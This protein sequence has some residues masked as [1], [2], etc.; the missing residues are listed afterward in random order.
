MAD[1][2]LSSRDVKVFP[3]AFRGKDASGAI[4]P[5]AFLT[6]EENLVNLTNKVTYL[7]KSYYYAEDGGGDSIMHIIINGYHFIVSAEKITEL[8]PNP[9]LNDNIYAS[10]FIDD[11]ATTY[12]DVDVKTLSPFGGDAGDILDREETVGSK[13]FKGLK[14]SN[15]SSSDS[16]LLFT[17]KSGSEG[18]YWSY[19]D[20][21]MVNI[22]TRQI[23]NGNDSYPITSAF[24]TDNLITHIA[25]I[26]ILYG[27]SGPIILSSHMVPGHGS[28]VL[29]DESLPF[30]NMYVSSI[31][32]SSSYYSGAYAYCDAAGYWSSSYMTQSGVDVS[33]GI[34]LSHYH[35]AGASTFRGTFWINDYD[36]NLLSGNIYGASNISTSSLN[37]TGDLIVSS[38]NTNN[39]QLY[40]KNNI[41]IGF[42]HASGATHSVILSAYNFDVN[43]TNAT[44]YAGR[45]NS[46]Y[47]N[48]DN[49]SAIYPIQIRN[50]SFG[51]GACFGWEY[52]TGAHYADIVKTYLSLSYYTGDL[53]NISHNIYLNSIPSV[54]LN[55]IP[56]RMYEHRVIMTRNMGSPFASMDASIVMNLRLPYSTLISNLSDVRH[57]L[58]T[59]CYCDGGLVNTGTSTFNYNSPL[60]VA[61]HMYSFG[62]EYAGYTKCIVQSFLLYSS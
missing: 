14:F 26:G 7:C 42:G 20:T 22:S 32:F 16:L 44:I 61:G 47:F 40:A 8:F 51:F 58:K 41:S 34:L 12:D 39:I 62:T 4:D 56:V 55:D 45:G 54:F 50:G 17:Y 43:T 30:I 5:G 29:G 49:A 19:V 35:H 11:L 1:K 46:L 23:C 31:T 2:Y 60:V 10:I 9:S 53:D 15:T 52:G 3:T 48:H 25:N 59:A 6:T 13:T 57:A 37:V 33:Y 38:T 36:I 21:S 24:N 28:V 27:Y 18:N